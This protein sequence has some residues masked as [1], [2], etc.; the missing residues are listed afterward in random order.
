MQK[1][2]ATLASRAQAS[3]ARALADQY[4]RDYGTTIL[5]NLACS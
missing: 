5:G 3:N 1:T 4:W 2:V